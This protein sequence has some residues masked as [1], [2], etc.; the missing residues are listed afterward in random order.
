MVT[1][2][3]EL[4]SKSPQ[5]SFS[6]FNINMDEY[7]TDKIKIK[8]GQEPLNPPPPEDNNLGLISQTEKSKM[9]A[10]QEP[11][12]PPPP[13]ENNLGLISQTERSKMKAD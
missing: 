1:D 9:K 5:L 7:E 12:T 3:Q 13:E 2:F 6:M 10:G 4:D 11:L 8:V